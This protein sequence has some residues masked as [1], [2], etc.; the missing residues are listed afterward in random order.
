MSYAERHLVSVTTDAS[1]DATA[2]TTDNITGSIH[3]IR[4]VKHGVTPFADTVDFTI[5]GAETGEP[6]LTIANVTATT[7]YSPRK[8]THGVEDGAVA[9]FAAG[10]SYVRAPVMIANERVKIVVA[11]GG[12]A[13]LG[14]FYVVVA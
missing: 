11:Q 9:L 14:S 2:Y 13:K 4:Y 5:T 10:G 3:S 12:N 7:T 1:G 6:I 8:A